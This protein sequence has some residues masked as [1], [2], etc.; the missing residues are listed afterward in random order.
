MTAK[1]KLTTTFFNRRKAIAVPR[2]RRKSKRTKRD[3]G[4]SV[5]SETTLGFCTKHK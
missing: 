1:A 5:D 3:V 2:K 4:Q